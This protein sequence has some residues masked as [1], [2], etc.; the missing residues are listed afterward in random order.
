MITIAE[1][2]EYTIRLDLVSNR[3]FLT[4]VGF[5]RTPDDVPSYLEDCKKAVGIL[6][7]GFTLLTDVTQMSI[8]PGEVRDIH[9]EAQQIITNAGVKKVAELQ[10]VKAAEL[11]LNG[12]AQE[13]GM[14]KK[15]FNSR[16]EAITWLNQP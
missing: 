8:H 10:K 6:K 7:P 11:Q 3:T 16:E 12:V 14:P 2:K 9:L 1:N 13:S 4:I 15:N 5:W